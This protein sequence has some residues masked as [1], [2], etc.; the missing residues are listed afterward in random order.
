MITTI[1]IT[2]CGCYFE[3]EADHLKDYLAR[4]VLCGNP[5]CSR[6]QARREREIL[7]ADIRATELRLNSLNDRLAG[8]R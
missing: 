4:W 1:K 7:K 3:Y 2:D 6:M 5:E 8:L